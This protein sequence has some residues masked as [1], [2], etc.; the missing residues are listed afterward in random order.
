MDTLIVT[1]EKERN[2][3]SMKEEIKIGPN[4]EDET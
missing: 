3:Q 1:R 2:Q 4:L